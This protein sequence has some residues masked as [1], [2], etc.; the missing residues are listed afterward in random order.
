MVTSIRSIEYQF[1]LLMSS[2]TTYLVDFFPLEA[3]IVY[4][5]RTTGRAPVGLPTISRGTRMP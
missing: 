4:A 5:E 1:L 2:L 3:N